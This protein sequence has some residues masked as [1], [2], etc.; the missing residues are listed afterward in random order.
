MY[1]SKHVRILVKQAHA[2]THL[3]KLNKDQTKDFTWFGQDDLYQWL[4][5]KNILF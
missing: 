3:T 4:A 5:T 2:H 1:C